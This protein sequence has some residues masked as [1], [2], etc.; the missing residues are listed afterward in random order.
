MK[1]RGQDMSVAACVAEVENCK[2]AHEKTRARHVSGDMCE[3][4]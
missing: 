1:K 3:R 4:S 2:V